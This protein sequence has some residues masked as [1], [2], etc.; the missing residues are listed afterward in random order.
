MNEDYRIGERAA[1]MG[2]DAGVAINGKWDKV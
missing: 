1:F 2:L